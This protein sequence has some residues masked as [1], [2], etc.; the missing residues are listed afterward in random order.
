MRAKL[1]TG[2]L[3]CGNPIKVFT[4]EKRLINYSTAGQETSQSEN[5]IRLCIIY[6]HYYTYRY[7]S[8]QSTPMHRAE[9]DVVATIPLN[10]IRYISSNAQWSRI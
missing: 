9:S 3:Y 2:A 6:T 7:C 10:G 4:R 8:T 1:P 5:Y